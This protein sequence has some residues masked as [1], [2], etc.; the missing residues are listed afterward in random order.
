MRESYI[1]TLD[2]SFEDRNKLHDAMILENYW[3]PSRS[4]K[5]GE[6]TRWT[7]EEEIFLLFIARMFPNLTYTD[8][9]NKGFTTRSPKAMGNKVHALRQT[10]IHASEVEIK[11]FKELVKEDKCFKAI[12]CVERGRVSFD[13]FTSLQLKIL[14]SQL[15]LKKSNHERGGDGERV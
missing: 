6:A 3:Q 7:R 4:S 5:T 8:L 13:R 12:Q 2:I 10:L 9:V 1:A 11:V 15:N 14:Y